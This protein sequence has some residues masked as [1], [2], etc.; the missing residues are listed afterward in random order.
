MP[1]PPDLSD[2]YG[3]I[4]S[5]L[6]AA[7]TLIGGAFVAL[8]RTRE[9][10]RENAVADALKGV[11]KEVEGLAHRLEGVAEKIFDRLTSLEKNQASQSARCT[12]LH[13]LDHR[14]DGKERR[15]EP[16]V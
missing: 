12:A 5:T 7:L 1:I 2:H 3:S 9:K 14:W 11:G 10:E 4:A 8:W 15:R 13:G 16:R 6:L